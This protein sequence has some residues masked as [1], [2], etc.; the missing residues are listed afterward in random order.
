MAYKYLLM[1]LLPLCHCRH[2]ENGSVCG[3]RENRDICKALLRMLLITSLHKTILQGEFTD[4]GTETHFTIGSYSAHIKSV[5]SGNKMKGL[6]Y[7]LVVENTELH[8]VK[9]ET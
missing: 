7:T 5:S 8:P 9:E 2:R 3:W 6:M 4:E 1:Y